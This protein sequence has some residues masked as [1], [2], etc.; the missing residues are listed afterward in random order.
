MADSTIS[1]I[2]TVG[3]SSIYYQVIIGAYVFFSSAA[4]AAATVVGLTWY[5]EKWGVSYVWYLNTGGFTFVALSVS[6]LII[7]AYADKS[8]SKYGRRKPYVVA[9]YI[10]NA[11][12]VLMVCAP[13]V[14]KGLFV[15][16]WYL[17]SSIIANIGKGIYT[18]P[19][20]TWIIESCV[21]N[22]EYRQIQTIA[23]NIGTLFGAL[24]GG[25]LTIYF[26]IFGALISVVGG[27]ITT[28]LLTWYIPS[29]VHRKVASLPPLI[30]S[31]RIAGR[32]NEFRT[33]FTN[34]VLIGT[35][36][37]IFSTNGSLLLLLGFGLGTTQDFVT[38]TTVLAVAGA[39][40]GIACVVVCNWYLKYVE[41]L[42]LYLQLAALVT[43]ISLIGFIVCIF[44]SQAAF[45][46]FFVLILIAGII[47]FPIT[48][49]ESL[50][51]RDL[52]LYDTFTT[53]LNRENT[54][55]T[56]ITLPPSVLV[57]V[58]TVVP[59]SALN[60]TGFSQNLVDDDKISGLYTWNNSSLWV[61]RVS[62]TLL[63]AVI[64]MASYY[65]IQKYPL[66]QKVADQMNAAVQKREEGKKEGDAEGGKVEM[67]NF[68]IGGRPSEGEVSGASKDLD[69]KQL[70]EKVMEDRLMLLH[71]SLEEI[72]RVA[73]GAS[74]GSAVNPGL[75]TVYRY[76]LASMVLS[77]ITSAMLLAAF[78]VDASLGGAHF[79]TLLLALFLLVGSLLIYEAMRQ[80]AILGLFEWP[81]SKI[82]DVAQAVTDD[83]SNYHET[84]KEKLQRGAIEVEEPV[85]AADSDATG[86]QKQLTAVAN[87]L[88]APIQDVRE[89]IAAASSAAEDDVV[90][91]TNGYK[92]IFSSMLAVLALAVIVIALDATGHLA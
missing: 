20:Q 16:F 4:G 29:V 22:S 70:E 15:T 5:V 41:K 67:T 62:G 7:S 31:I 8:E 83:F 59:L 10:V 3:L 63:V 33:I 57:A 78:F 27:G 81:A 75:L 58:L 54:Y 19:Y 40:G 13:P 24:F 64:A 14:T 1:K 88:L 52:I 77:G 85:G 43:A 68:G 44:T 11:I 56:A 76:T 35:A 89:T 36:T 45:F 79:C 71:L 74:K 91:P 21:D 32:T 34:R 49:I 87:S 50:M 84:L 38:Y 61:L 72:Q 12:G 60:L 25:L 46:V 82:K 18:N 86:D 92:R 39:L 2:P 6:E 37:G 17:I 55:L 53:G 30:P 42:G 48:L 90:K 65:L 66:T 28:F 80:R 69:V 73:T 9:G 47:Y 51:V 26:P 23:T